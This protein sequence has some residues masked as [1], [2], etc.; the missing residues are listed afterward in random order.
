MSHCACGSRTSRF[1]YEGMRHLS[2]PREEIGGYIQKQ[3]Q[4]RAFKS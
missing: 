4:N 2:F 1:G 3:R